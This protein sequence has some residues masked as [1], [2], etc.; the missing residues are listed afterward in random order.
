MTDL[1]ALL[2]RDPRSHTREDRDAFIRMYRERR[3]QYNAAPQ[4]TTKPVTEKKKD[5]L[6]LHDALKGSLDL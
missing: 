5:L 1:Q 6:S 3:H 4:K 2:D